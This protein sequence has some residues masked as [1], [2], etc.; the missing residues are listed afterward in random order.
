METSVRMLERLVFDRFASM[1]LEFPT[2][3][4]SQARP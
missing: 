2:G 3:S 4:L 1:L